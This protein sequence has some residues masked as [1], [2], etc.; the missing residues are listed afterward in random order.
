M[1]P[2]LVLGICDEQLQD[3]SVCIDDTFRQRECTAMTSPND[4][5]QGM[6][7]PPVRSLLSNLCLQ[8]LLIDLIQFVL[9]TEGQGSC[10]R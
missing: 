4:M 6:A 3:S 8:A 7:E 1:K 10:A 2:F 5:G 9:V